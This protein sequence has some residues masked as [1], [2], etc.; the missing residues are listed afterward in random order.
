MLLKALMAC[1]A[2][3]LH[4]TIPRQSGNKTSSLY[5][6]TSQNLLDCLQDS[7][8]DSALCATTAIALSVYE[9]LS[10][11]NPHSTNHVTGTRALIKECGWDANTPGL[12]GACFWLNTTIELLTCLRSNCY[13]AWDL[14]SWNV[15]MNM[16]ALKLYVAG[17]EE[18]WTRHMIYICA[19][20]TNHRSSMGQ[21]HSLDHESDASQINQRC[22]EWDL[23]KKWC[24]QWASTV[25]RSMK[26]LA[27]I[28]PP[29]D[30]TGSAFPII[31]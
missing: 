2:R 7:G 25:P 28:N 8:R 20:V 1:G 21:F 30:S 26:P 19:K 18:L 23:Y 14:D 24:D 6:M 12:G 5:D 9:V 10:P 16:D 29:Q 13:Q 3:R 11:R 15:D 22:Q 27:Y 31:W 17:N 4:N